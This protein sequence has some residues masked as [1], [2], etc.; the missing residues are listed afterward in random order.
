MESLGS[1]VVAVVW[2]VPLVALAGGVLAG[3]AVT[4]WRRR[5]IRSMER[6]EAEHDG[7]RERAWAEHDGPSRT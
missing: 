3:V 6:A 1:L 2:G 7:Q 5:A 4:R